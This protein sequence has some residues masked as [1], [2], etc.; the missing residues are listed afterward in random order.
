MG[1][2]LATVTQPSTTLPHQ[3]TPQADTAMVAMV[4]MVA[5]AAD[6]A[7]EAGFGLASSAVPSQAPHSA[8]AGHRLTTLATTAVGVA[9]AAAVA[10]KPS[11]PVHAQHL[12]MEALADDKAKPTGDKYQFM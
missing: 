7:L 2:V 9:A 5:M 12:A 4:A 6:A 3:P 8:A 10:V 11:R 1:V